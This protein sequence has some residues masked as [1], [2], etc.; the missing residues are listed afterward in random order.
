[1]RDPVG[2]SEDL[3]SRVKAHMMSCQ[4]P[5]QF[6]ELVILFNT[7]LICFISILMLQSYILSHIGIKPSLLG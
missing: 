5:Q 1:M 6:N 2:N 7:S 3:F 4:L